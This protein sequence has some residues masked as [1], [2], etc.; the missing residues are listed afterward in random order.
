MATTDSLSSCGPH[1][2]AQLLPPSAHAPNPIGVILR[3]ELPSCRYS[4]SSLCCAVKKSDQINHTNRECELPTW[5]LCL[6]YC[7]GH[8]RHIR[9]VK[10]F[11]T[12]L[13]INLV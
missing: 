6:A 9:V 2:A 7:L 3:S 12:A 10:P 13:L 5:T 8:R 4:I 11:C 1:E